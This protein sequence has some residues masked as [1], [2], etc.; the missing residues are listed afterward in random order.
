MV[1]AQEADRENIVRELHDDIGQSLKA[2][3]L[4]L[5]AIHTSGEVHES[6][7]S[8]LRESIDVLDGVLRRVRELSSDLR[9]ANQDEADQ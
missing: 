3:S 2:I 8:R 5:K 1:N 6:A 9:P 4:N 7:V